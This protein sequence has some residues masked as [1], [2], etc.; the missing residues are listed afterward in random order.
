MPSGEPRIWRILVVLA[1]MAVTVAAT[2]APAR[3]DDGRLT[4]DQ[5][6]AN[7]ALIARLVDSRPGSARIE[8]ENTNAFFTTADVQ[9]TGVTLVPGPVPGGVWAELGVIAPGETAT[10]SATWNPRLASQVFVRTTPYLLQ[11]DA[12]GLAAAFTV[13]SIVGDVVLEQLPVRGQR[14]VHS[15]KA[16]REA[17]GIITPLFTDLGGTVNVEGLASGALAMEV[18][19]ILGDPTKAELLRQALDLFGVTVST[20]TLKEL[21]HWVPAVELGHKT[22]RLATA[23]ITQTSSG[24]AV[25]ASAGTQVPEAT[26]PDLPTPTPSPEGRPSPK[27]TPNPVTEPPIRATTDPSGLDGGSPQIRAAT[28]AV[29]AVQQWTDSGVDLAA[30]DHLYIVGSGTIKIAG[31]DPG[32]HT[33]GDTVGAAPVL[34]CSAEHTFT[35]P[36]RQ[37]YGM[38]ARIGSGAPFDVLASV[39]LTADSAGRLFLGVNDDVFTDNSGSWIADVRACH[40]GTLH[41]CVIGR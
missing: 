1:V 25:F 38:I 36:G 11:T 6:G 5:S 15:A 13:L 3:A 9:V 33:N 8:I 23:L 31:S 41:A 2:V 20:N 18:L 19:E 4:V 27:P 40:G 21:L 14:V 35:A 39:S 32:K 30:G 10:W 7:H 34:T 24:G 22:L 12:G 26:T 16:L 28:V 37:C 17:A 29:P